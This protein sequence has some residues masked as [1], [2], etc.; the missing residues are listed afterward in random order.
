MVRKA[1]QPAEVPQASGCGRQVFAAQIIWD[2]L[3]S[4]THHFTIRCVNIEFVFHIGR[5]QN[6]MIKSLFVPA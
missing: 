5:I 3:R 2:G 4:D 1:L 6:E